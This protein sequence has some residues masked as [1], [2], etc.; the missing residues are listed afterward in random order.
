VWWDENFIVPIPSLC[1]FE[2]NLFKPYLMFK[3]ITFTVLTMIS[4]FLLNAQSLT[5]DFEDLNLGV[6]SFYNGQDFAGQFTS[7]GITFANNYDTAG[8]FTSWTGFAAS[9][10]TDTTTA[11][12]MNQSS[13]F[14]GSG[15]NGSSTFGVYYS[16][17]NDSINFPNDIQLPGFYIT[18]S[19]Y[20]AIAMRDGDAFTKQYGGQ[21]GM[22]PDYFR[23]RFQGFD[24]SSNLTGEVVFYLA[25]YRSPNNNQDYIVKD[26]TRVDLTPLGT[27]R[28]FAIVFESSDTGQ[29][30]INT[31][32]YF[33]LDDFELSLSTGISYASASNAIRV[34]PNPVSNSLNL[35]LLESA[36]DFEHYQIF[37]TSGAIIKT[38][39]I[40]G[41]TQ[42][43]DVSDLPPGAYILQVAGQSSV[44]KRFIKQ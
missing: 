21:S 1:S 5:A 17:S 38:A 13:A 8:G 20:A 16:F 24:A 18:N 26:W 6:D 9:T 3:K 34:Y 15:Y 33:C 19:T 11:G 39:S 29:F 22:D 40:T 2:G 36:N 44:V 14:A 4:A 35:E 37:N 31:P 30:G 28:K 25:D 7:Q 41:S 23:V 32:T 42:Q 10:R 27:I 43:I 12:F